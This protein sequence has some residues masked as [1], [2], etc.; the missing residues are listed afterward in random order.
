MKLQ[1]SAT[2]R[3][4]ER[5][6]FKSSDWYCDFKTSPVIGLGPEE[7]VHRRDPSSL[8]KVNDTYYVYYSKS[9]GE[10]VG[11][12]TG[13]PNAKV[14]PWDYCDLWFATSK[15]A[16]TWEEKGIAVARG[17]KGNYDDRSVFTPEV[18]AH[19][20]KYYLVYQCVKHPYVCRVK[21]TIGMAVSQNPAGPFTKLSNPILFASE[22]GE[23][24]GNS[25]NRFLVKEKGDFD[26]H[27]VHDP[28]LLYFRDKFYLY[29]KG[30]RM[31]EELYMG[32]RE[33]KW[34]V[35]I[36]DKPDGPYVK[37]PY[38]PIT[39]S[40]HETCVWHYQ[41]GIGALLTT[42]G[43]E[44]NTFQYAEDG[45][46]FEITGSIKGAPEAL[47][48]YRDDKHCNDSPLDGIRWGLCHDVNCKWHYIMRFDVDEWQK[49]T[50][51]ARKSYE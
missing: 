15:D 22:T 14:F 10:H 26:S 42:D 50:Y 46:N 47:G 51:N 36:S 35:A 41:D 1:S 2:K 4:L 38:N 7:G 18:L 48:P 32:G 5:N 27:K 16:K 44:R 21:N 49:K 30:E 25:D 12:G 43:M 34:G 8:I 45:I 28:C 39:N 3:A 11:F 13:D 23:W 19:N 20:G 33:T 9:Y 40:G 29:Y 24:E 17:N 31:G 37:S 6:Y